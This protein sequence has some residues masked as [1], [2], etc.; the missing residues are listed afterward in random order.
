MVFLLLT[1]HIYP[2]TLGAINIHLT[3]C[4]KIRK[5]VMHDRKTSHGQTCQRPVLS[6]GVQAGTVSVPWEYPPAEALDRHPVLH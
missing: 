2:E 5:T 6:M 4:I 1:S 3:E